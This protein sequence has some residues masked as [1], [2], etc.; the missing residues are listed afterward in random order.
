VNNWR[1]N[2][3]DKTNPASLCTTRCPPPPSIS[4]CRDCVFLIV[5]TG[6][7]TVLFSGMGD[8]DYGLNPIRMTKCDLGSIC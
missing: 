5:F 2:T 6:H 8:V 4:P 7:T 3:S 1:R